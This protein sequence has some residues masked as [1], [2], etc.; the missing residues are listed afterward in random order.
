[1]MEICELKHSDEKKWD[2]YVLKHPYS[3]FYHQI[4]WKNIVENSYGH[5]PYYL[6]AKD[7]DEIKG[8]FPLFLI[9]NLI[10]GTKLVSV[11][12]APY[13]GAISDNSVI[14]ALLIE[15]GR[16]ITDETSAN[17]M[18]LRNNVSRNVGLP[19]NDKYLTMI[20]KLDKNPQLVWQR[21]FNNKIRNAAKK[22]LKSE[23]EVSNSNVED[24]YKLYSKNMRDLGSPSH[25]KEFFNNVILESGKL[26]E[27]I[28]VSHRGKP[29]SSAILFLFNL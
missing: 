29:V 10:F 14:E 21:D 13:G 6:F 24:F 25:S 1:M 27:I 19:C 23:L 18:E 20:L 17:Y 3:T 7:E 12:F 15:Y 22:S 5:K 2:E 9:K 8:V 11:P 4:Y 16:K 26:A 28:A